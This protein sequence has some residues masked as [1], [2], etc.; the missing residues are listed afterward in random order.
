MT[1]DKRLSMLGLCRRAGR[2]MWGHDTCLLSVR[3]GSARLCLLARDA[4]ERQVRDLQ[5]AADRAGS[6][7]QI[8]RMPYTMQE[9]KDAAGCFAGVLSIEDEG[10]AK[11]L[12]ELFESAPLD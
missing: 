3:R 4:S 12:A 2:L 7:P 10:F 9:I 8:I 5:F 6:A 11:R 1:Q